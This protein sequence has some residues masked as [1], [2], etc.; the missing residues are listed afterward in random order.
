[1][2]RNFFSR[3]NTSQKKIS[4]DKSGFER[5]VMCGEITTVPFSMPVMFRECYEVGCGQFC[6]NCY[7]N[8]QKEKQNLSN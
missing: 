8:L 4:P 5:C 6:G 2:K 7:K 3:K 1:M